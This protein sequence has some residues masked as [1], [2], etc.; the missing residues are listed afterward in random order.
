MAIR[1][2]LSSGILACVSGAFGV[3]MLTSNL[4]YMT[5]CGVLQA[6]AAGMLGCWAAPLDSACLHH[7]HRPNVQ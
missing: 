5:L 3:N 6:G 4:L 7:V 1:V 2:P